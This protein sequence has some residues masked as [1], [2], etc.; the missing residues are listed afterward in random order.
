MMKYRISLIAVCSSVIFTSGCST[1]TSPARIHELESG[2]SYWFDYDATRR[3]TILVS[4][5]S[6]AKE[7]VLRSCAEPAPDVALNLASKIE[8]QLSYKDISGQAKGDLAINAVKLAERSQMVMFFREAL[9]RLCEI[10]VNS[11]LS[12]TEISN[13]YGR[14]IDT[15]LRLGSDKAI[16][17]DLTKIKLELVQVEAAM[18]SAAAQRAQAEADKAKANDAAE[19]QRLQQQ[20]DSL[21][22]QIAKAGE[23]KKALGTQLVSLSEAKKA[24]A[25]ADAQ[26]GTEAKEK[27]EE[28]SKDP[29]KA[30]AP[31]K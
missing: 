31:I 4:A 27:G 21:N 24:E 16:D 29:T 15:A 6:N 13:L 23:D 17:V 9:F 1:L 25:S 22:I 2:K 3:G 14:I 26:K 30:V 19:R 18:A 5:D 28:V 12:S 7:K 20:I 8:S 10:S 11:S